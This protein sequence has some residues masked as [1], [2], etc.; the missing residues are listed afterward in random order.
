M[1]TAFVHLSKELLAQSLAS[2]LS[3]AA[4]TVNYQALVSVSQDIC[5]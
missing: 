1:N 3:H 5:A 2:M 4:K